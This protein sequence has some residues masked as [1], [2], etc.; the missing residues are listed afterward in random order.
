MK[1]TTPG[2]PIERKNLLKLGC[3]TFLL[4]FFTVY[5]VV[6]ERIMTRPYGNDEH[7]TNSAFLVFLNRVVSVLFSSVIMLYHKEPLGAIAPHWTYATIS[8][9][10]L[11]AT[12]CQYEALKYLNFPL[13]TVLKN[14]KIV[15]VLAVTR[16]LLGKKYGWKDYIVALGITLGCSAFV[17]TGESLKVSDASAGNTYY[18]MIGLIIMIT[19]LFF[20]GFT[21]TFQEKLFRGYSMSTNHQIFYVNCYSALLSA[22]GLFTSGQLSSSLE[23]SYR[24]PY[25]LVDALELSFC[26]TFGQQVI[27]VT[28]KEFGNVLLSTV[29]TTRQMLSIVVSSMIYLHSLSTVQWISAGFISCCLYY[30]TY[31]RATTAP[32]YTRRP[33]SNTTRP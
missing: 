15:M 17:L 16:C 11:A 21:S 24:H 31:V 23:F 30:S 10:N 28:I 12:F 9:C 18:T 29:M 6:Q 4:L 26:S 13:Q 27:Y 2:A 5:G 33:T 14:G 22:A 25:F 7:F 8:L 20:D 19:Y 1:N 32:S 3:I